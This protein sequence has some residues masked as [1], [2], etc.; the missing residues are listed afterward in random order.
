MQMKQSYYNLLFKKDERK[1][2]YNQ[3]STSILE[4]DDTLYH[5]LINDDI[6]KIPEDIKESLLNLQFL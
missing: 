4:L 1:L 6:E 5:C 2:V 3:L